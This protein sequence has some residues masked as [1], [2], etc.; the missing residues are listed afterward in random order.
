MDQDRSNEP[1]PVAQLET[2]GISPADQFD[3]W[4]QAASPLFDT[5]IV[6]A[7]K[8]FSAGAT[9][10]LVDQLVFTHVHFDRMC[11]TR[12]SRHLGRG[13]EDCISLQL[14]RSGSIQGQLD[15]STPLL[16]A[17]DRVS[18]QDFAHGYSGIGESKD[19][20]GVIIPRHL[21]LLQDRIYRERPMF[22]WDVNSPQG[23]LIIS[24]LAG[25]WRSLPH[26][27]Q[28][29][30]PAIAS[31]FVGL[32]NGLLAAEDGSVRHAEHTEATKLAMQDYLQT[33][34][35]RIDLGPNDLCR[36]FHC[37]RAT[38]YRLFL[39][40]GGVKTYLR[41]LRLECCCKELAIA[42][43]SSPGV[44]H[45]VAER[46]GFM[47]PSHFH[48]LFKQH[49]GIAP[50]ELLTAREEPRLPD[51]INPVVASAAQVERLRGWLQQ[52]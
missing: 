17:P 15:D 10:Y 34:L 16:M 9:C 36:A 13:D 6:G 52:Y 14:Y 49:Y 33:N 3:A 30:A 7:S 26:A 44:V 46:W 22:S 37:S 25:I 29:Q 2:I 39:E 27:V 18:I 24:A 11:F 1:I 38:V 12:H 31:G 48:R 42:D 35:H 40:Y 32:I 41:N 45:Q 28:K 5:A 19:N 23:R 51:H 47:D 8:S 50:S 43:A 20:Y 4:H 21:V